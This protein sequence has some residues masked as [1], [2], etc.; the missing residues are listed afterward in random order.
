MAGLRSTDKRLIDPTA[1]FFPAGKEG[2]KSRV[3]S[4]K[5]PSTPQNNSTGIINVE[6]SGVSQR[7]QK[8]GFAFPANAAA[9]QK[10]R[11]SAP[12]AI[13]RPVKMPQMRELRRLLRQ[14]ARSM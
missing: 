8:K 1:R 3:D 6:M 5:L 2:G 10:R 7:L 14:D 13:I 4:G 9:S 12:N 11:G